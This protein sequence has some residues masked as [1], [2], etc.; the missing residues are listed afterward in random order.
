M[1]DLLCCALVYT[2][3]AL[4][5]HSMAIA[6][7]GIIIAI[8]SATGMRLPILLF[9]A[10]MCVVQAMKQDNITCTLNQIGGWY[11]NHHCLV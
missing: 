2:T 4:N 7:S 5:E 11:E 3:V 1:F 6:L 10:R 9:C 8:G